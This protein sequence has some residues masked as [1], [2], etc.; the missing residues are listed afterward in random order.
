MRAL[1]AFF[2][3]A[4]FIAGLAAPPPGDG[5]RLKG[6]PPKAWVEGGLV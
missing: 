4:A 2:L 5:L 3:I 1:S 6:G